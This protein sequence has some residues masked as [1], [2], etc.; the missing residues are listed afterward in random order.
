MVLWAQ[1]HL[2]PVVYHLLNH[3][4]PVKQEYEG[5]IPVSGEMK[6]HLQWWLNKPNLR[7][8]YTFDMQALAW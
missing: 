4:P 8:R 5:L 7:M 3:D 2:K 1:H 6:V